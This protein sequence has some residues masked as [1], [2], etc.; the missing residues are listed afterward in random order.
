MHIH[1]SYIVLYVC[2]CVYN[3][4]SAQSIQQK[5]NNIQFCEHKF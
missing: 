3:I 2:I 4:R 5:N 1:K